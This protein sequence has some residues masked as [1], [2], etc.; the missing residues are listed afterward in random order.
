MQTA[1]SLDSSL[2]TRDRII[3]AVGELFYR[4]GT[5]LLG[6]DSLVRHLRITRAT[7]YR[8]FRGKEGLVLAYLRHRHECV[9]R[10]LLDLV[11][12]KSGAEAVD[13][14]FAS[15]ETKTRDEHY[16]GCAFV[17]AVTENPRSEAIF[18]VGQEHKAFLRALFVRL[19]QAE[20]DRKNG[21]NGAS[22]ALA[23]QLLLLYEGALAASVLRPQARPATT[24]RAIVAML[25][26]G[27]KDTSCGAAQ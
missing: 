8:H 22:D 2:P 16:R 11:T 23:D 20:P 26:S 3:A 19:L 21:V 14:I 15:L 12:D 27:R 24:A 13:A 10:Q 4:H 9:S 6:V 17:I 5:Y 1:S 18:A 7:L 25:L